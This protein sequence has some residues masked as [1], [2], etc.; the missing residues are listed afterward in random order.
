MLALGIEF[1]LQTRFATE[2]NGNVTLFACWNRTDSLS[3]RLRQRLSESRPRSNNVGKF[4]GGAVDDVKV[5]TASAARKCHCAAKTQNADPDRH[6]N[7][8]TCNHGLN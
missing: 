6:E 3:E 4:G 7:A 1:E 5:C 2:T 8:R